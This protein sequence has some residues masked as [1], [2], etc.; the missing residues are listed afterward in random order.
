MIRWAGIVICISAILFLGFSL[1]F[2]YLNWAYPS[3]GNSLAEYTVQLMADGYIEGAILGMCF[4]PIIPILIYGSLRATNNDY[5]KIPRITPHFT[6]YT[7]V[8]IVVLSI[9]TS[10]INVAAFGLRKEVIFFCV[11]IST[12]FVWML[13]SGLRFTSQDNYHKA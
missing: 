4:M 3:A 1:L 5:M 2:L 8:A 11:V 13:S 10:L 9:F 6:R 7:V 12:I